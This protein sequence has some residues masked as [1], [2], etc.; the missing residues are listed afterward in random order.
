VLEVWVRLG[1][2]ALSLLLVFMFFGRVMCAC[3]LGGAGVEQSAM[4]SRSGKRRGLFVF[5]F[6]QLLTIPM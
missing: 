3:V 4:V 6:V 5:V 2:L 1:G